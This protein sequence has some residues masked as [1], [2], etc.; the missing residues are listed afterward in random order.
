MRQGHTLPTPG[1]GTSTDMVGSLW[2]S[3]VLAEHVVLSG[4]RVMGYIPDSPLFV[5]VYPEK[6]NQHLVSY[7]DLVTNPG[8]L[9]DPNLVV[10]VNEK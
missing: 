8:L 5:P 4:L 10:K 2:V 7:Q 9:E 3:Y 1:A 6:F